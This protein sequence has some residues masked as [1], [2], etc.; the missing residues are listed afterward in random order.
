MKWCCRYRSADVTTE[1]ANGGHIAPFLRDGC[2]T[3]CLRGFR[4]MRERKTDNSSL[5]MTAAPWNY[6]YHRS[7]QPNGPKPSEVVAASA[8]SSHNISS[9]RSFR[10]RFSAIKRNNVQERATREPGRPSLLYGTEDVY[11]PLLLTFRLTVVDSETGRR[12]WLLHRGQPKNNQIR[13]RKKNGQPRER[14]PSWYFDT[15][16]TSWSLPS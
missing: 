13:Q 8:H 14:P 16:T 11:L 10:I 5:L 9:L 3:N 4:P 6:E 15:R 2:N 7:P 12:D 1:F